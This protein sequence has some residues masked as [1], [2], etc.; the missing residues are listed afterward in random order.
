MSKLY[1]EDRHMKYDPNT[2]RYYITPEYFKETYGINLD[3]WKVVR[4]DANPK[5][6]AERFLKRLS[7]NLYTY[8]LSFNRDSDYNI[9]LLAG[10]NPDFREPLK[11]ALGEYAY[12]I[13]LAG[14]DFSVVSGL[15]FDG[16]KLSKEDM[17]KQ[18]VASGVELILKDA[19]ILWAGKYLEKDNDYLERKAL[20][21]Y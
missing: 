19:G 21:D 2:H 16:K 20:G 5:T 12:Q 15:S 3:D 7:M 4:E 6:A 18:M 10:G 17:M 9:Y 1:K 11:E 14:N 13:Y 8:I